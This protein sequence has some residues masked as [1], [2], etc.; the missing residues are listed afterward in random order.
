MTMAPYGLARL[1]DAEL[2]KDGADGSSGLSARP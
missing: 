1:P 2:A